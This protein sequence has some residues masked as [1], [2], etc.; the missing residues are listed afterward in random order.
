MKK[1]VISALALAIV[2]A[3]GVGA[4]SDAQAGRPSC[5]V[6]KVDTGCCVAVGWVWAYYCCVA[7]GGTYSDC[8]W[9]VTRDKKGC[10]P[11]VPLC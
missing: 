5:I 8:Y 9:D 6:K 11:G 7:P 10:P 3:I 4:L 2:I 1:T